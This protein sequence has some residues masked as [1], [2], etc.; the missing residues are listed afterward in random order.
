LYEL[1]KNYLGTYI[2][3]AQSARASTTQDVQVLKGI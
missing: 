3:Y 2:A 1:Y